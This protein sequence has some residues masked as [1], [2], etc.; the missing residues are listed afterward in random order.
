[1]IALWIVSKKS[2]IAQMVL[3]GFRRYL[4]SPQRFQADAERKL[5]IILDRKAMKCFNAV[6]GQFQMFYKLGVDHLE[7]QPAFVA[8]CSRP[9]CRPGSQASGTGSSRTYDAAASWNKFR[10]EP[11]LNH[12]ICEAP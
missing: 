5:P 4:H 8:D 6:R 3:V 7:Y 1:M 11:R 9:I 2:R 10:A 12:S